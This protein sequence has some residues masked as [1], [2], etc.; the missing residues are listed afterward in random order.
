MWRLG[1]RGPG[2]LKI[3]DFGGRSFCFDNRPDRIER[4]GLE[5]FKECLLSREGAMS[6]EVGFGVFGKAS[7]FDC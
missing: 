5:E 2:E 1:E 7:C 4:K 3:W 6:G